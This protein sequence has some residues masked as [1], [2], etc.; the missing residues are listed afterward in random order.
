[1]SGYY[2]VEHS[3]QRARKCKSEL[4]MATD[5]RLNNGFYLP[6]LQ[7]GLASCRTVSDSLDKCPATQWSR[8]LPTPAVRPG[9]YRATVD[10]KKPS[11]R[12]STAGV[13]VL[14][15]TSYA[16]LTVRA[17]AA[18]AKV[19]PA[20]AYTYFSSKNH[21]IA[22]VY[23]DLVRQVPL[24]HRRQRAHADASGQGAAP[25]GAGG[26]RRT[27]G[28]RG[29]HDGVAWR[30]R[31]PRR[32]V[33][34]RPDRRGDPPPHRLSHRPRRR[35]PHR[36]GPGDDVLRRTGACRQRGH[37]PTTRSPTGLPTWSA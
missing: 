4:A 16:D 35:A 34:A 36:V 29:V 15:E 6:C 14:R 32:A 7:N 10:R 17:V 37:S 20:T 24:L 26:R 2:P 18:R 12:C 5:V 27:R 21:L 22:E 11:A 30:Q 23:L 13:E 28:R 1:M 31:R 19:A 8:S 3:L 9:T 33:G 25:S